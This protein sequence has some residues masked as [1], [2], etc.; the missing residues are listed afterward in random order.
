MTAHRQPA[1]RGKGQPDGLSAKRAGRGKPASRDQWPPSGPVRD[2]LAYCD[3]VRQDNGTPSLRALGERMHLAFARVGELLRS[4]LP[5]DEE[6]ARALLKALGAEDGNEVD[7]GIALYGKAARA[8]RGRLADAGPPT[9]WLRSWYAGQVGDIAPLQL[10]DRG[11]EL[12]ELAGWCASGDE[13]YAWWQAG[14]RAGKSALMAWLVLH[15]PPGTWVVSFFVTARLAGQADSAAFTDA[16]LDQLAALTGE[17][18]PPVTS[19]TVR[20]GL[21]RQLLERSAAQAVKAGRR[22]ILVVDGL[23]EDCGSLP[24]SRLASIAACLPKR[25]PGSLRVL[26]AGRS[27]PPLPS[28]VDADHPLRSCRVRRLDASPHAAQVT[29]LAQRELDEILA[30]DK[31]RHGGLGYDVLGLVTA[32]GGGLGHRDLQE[33]T[34]RPAFEV[35]LLLRGVFGR[36]VAGCAVPDT[37]PRGFLFTHETLREQAIDRLGPGILAGFATRLHAWAEGYRDRGW[38]VGTPAYLLRGYPRML[39]DAGDVGRLAALATDP[40]RHQRM[41]DVTGGDAAALAEITAAHALVSASPSPDLLAA[42]RLAWHRDQLT[43]RNTNIPPEFPAVWETLGQPARAEALA[44]SI[45]DPDKCAKALASLAEAAARAGDLKRAGALAD[46]AVEQAARA[47]GAPDWRARAL[48]S[49][50]EATAHAA[51]LDRAEALARSIFPPDQQARALA[52]L[53][54]AAARAGDLSRAEALARSVNRPDEQARALASIADV[55]EPARARSCI[56]DALA[57]GRWVIPLKE[58]ADIDPAVLL[59]FADELAGFSGLLGQSGNGPLSG[60]SARHGA[61]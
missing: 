13:A 39:A 21:R 52:S 12:E 18:V 31:T 54:E 46:A 19:P 6:Q 9:W 55:A 11:G 2:W 22:L 43:D 15:P 10:L 4:E 35:D 8:E 34:G 53:A 24:G 25:P 60:T 26:V 59:A 36:T 20:D 56:A 40:A 16:L 37:A 14:P 47:A 44:R 17:Q 58:L 49:A 5:V 45:T 32:S 30:T 1:D 48:A 3:Q 57:V 7:R 50:A 28:D 51:D 33:L 38:P 61:G 29:E 27:D 23:D 42:L 41:L